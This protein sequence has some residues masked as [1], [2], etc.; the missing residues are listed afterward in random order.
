MSSVFHFG[1]GVGAVIRGPP[2]VFGPQRLGLGGL[3][4]GGPL[5]T[6]GDPLG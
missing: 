1:E 3:A 4:G 5:H 2:A 6:H